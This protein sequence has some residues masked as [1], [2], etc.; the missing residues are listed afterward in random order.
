MKVNGFN[1]KKSRMPCHS[2]NFA[3]K[4]GDAKQ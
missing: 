2:E 1:L 3:M 4:F